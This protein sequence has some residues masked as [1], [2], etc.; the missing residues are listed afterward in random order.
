VLPGAMRTEL[1]DG[2][3]DDGAAGVDAAGAA[4]GVWADGVCA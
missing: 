2:N 4:G 1:N 3:G